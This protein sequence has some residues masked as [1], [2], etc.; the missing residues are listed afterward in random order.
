M[1]AHPNGKERC[2]QFVSIT[3]E[4]QDLVVSKNLPTKRTKVLNAKNRKWPDVSTLKESLSRKPLRKT[5]LGSK[6][7]AINY[8]FA[9]ISANR[10]NFKM[11]K[12]FTIFNYLFPL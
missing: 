9:S 10:K 5:L 7:K 11:F 8:F 2:V 6:H 4:K 3:T 12:T 1:C